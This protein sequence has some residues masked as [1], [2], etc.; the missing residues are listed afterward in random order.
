M[1]R[2]SGRGVLLDIE[3]TVA[4]IRFVYDVL[5]TYAR[6][7]L[8]EFLRDRGSDP[9]VRAACEQTVREAIDAGLISASDASASSAPEIDLVVT[10][11]V[12]LMDTDAKV[13]GL[14]A[15]QGLIW[16]GG[17]R[18]GEL[19]AQLFADVPPAL[20]AWR[21]RGLD[22]RIYSSGS[23]AAQKL[24]FAHTTAG[25]LSALLRGYYD[26]TTGPKRAAESYR[27]I[28]ADLGLPGGEILFLS[29]VVAELDAAAEAGLATA[30]V[31]R[32][33]NPPRPAGHGHTI[34]HSLAEI[35]I[36]SPA[37][38]AGNA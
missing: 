26:T 7:H 13:T 35:E 22:V 17:F 19:K 18:A 31:V 36:G 10:A 5:F 38:A 32:P 29:D 2:F 28:A 16:E 23:I 11:A 9:Q 34:I 1:I 12:K 6:T 27:R 8:A 21:E 25:D 15:L 24:L 20:A 30:L 37:T 3:G 14:K 33:E 4:S